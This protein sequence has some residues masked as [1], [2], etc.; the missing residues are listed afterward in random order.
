MALDGQWKSDRPSGNFLLQ[1]SNLGHLAGLDLGLE[2]LELVG[3]LGQ[4]GLDLLA[5]L[6]ARVDVVCDALE[7]VFAEAARGHSGGADADAHGGEGRL[8]AGRGVLVAGDVDLFEHGFYAGAVEVERL[9]VEQDH[10][11]ICAVGNELVVHG[12]EGDFEGFCVGNDLAL[13]ELEVFGL[14]LL[15]RHSERGDGVVVGTALVAG[16]D[17][18]I[19]GALEV[20]ERFFARLGVCLAHAFAEED[21]GATRAAQRLVCCGGDDVAVGE[22]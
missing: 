13:V 4:L 11:V 20:V 12:F 21:H 3:L 14:G 15:E 1:G 22:G 7:V 2:V 6:N 17:G 19:D 18:E 16:E 5:Q 8:V 10:V 9:E